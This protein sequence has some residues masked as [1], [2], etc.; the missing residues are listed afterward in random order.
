M[1]IELLHFEGCLD[2]AEALNIFEEA[3]AEK[4]ISPKVEQVV[5]GPD[6]RLDSPESPRSWWAA[7][8]S[9]HPKA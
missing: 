6:N 2:S 8:I 9:S 4:G 7:R 5:I 3:L 1:R